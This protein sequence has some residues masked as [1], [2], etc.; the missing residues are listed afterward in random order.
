MTTVPS[1]LT[2][3]VIGAT[4]FVGFVLLRSWGG[5]R[6][7]FGLY[8]AVRA[9][10]AGIVIATLLAGL[11]EGVGLN[12]LG[13]AMATSVP[14]AALAARR[15][16]RSADDRTQPIRLEPAALA[17]PP[18]HQPAAVPP[19]PRAGVGSSQATPSETEALIGARRARSVDGGA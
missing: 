3:L 14:L 2:L 13:A 1:P 7:V 5:L 16:L 18:P 15:A 11:V 9:G 19:E 12:V 17:E 8:P 4:L 6:R 10:L